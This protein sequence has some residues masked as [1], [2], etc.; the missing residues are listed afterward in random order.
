VQLA[1]QSFIP[2]Y[3]TILAAEASW[4]SQEMASLPICIPRSEIAAMFVF[5]SVQRST[6]LEPWG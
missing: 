3:G 1:A 4:A 6:K 2:D 5:E